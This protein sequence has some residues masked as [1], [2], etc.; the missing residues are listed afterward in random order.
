MTQ[1]A[2]FQERGII[3]DTGY[4]I[5]LFDSRDEHHERAVELE[6]AVMGR[7]MLTPWPMLYEL[8]RTRFV[9]NT[10]AVV[11]FEQ[12]L[13]PRLNVLIDDSPYR[14][15]ALH[16]SLRLA[17]AERRSISLVDMVTRHMLEDAK[18]IVTHLVT[19]NAKDFS[20]ICE[21]RGILIEP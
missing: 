11:R 5:A 21:Q 14:K 6:E 10:K 12:L 19:F 8:V 15:A 17:A 18:L 4:W 3:V 7:A 2:K 16:Q 1:R 20:D 9:R 13:M